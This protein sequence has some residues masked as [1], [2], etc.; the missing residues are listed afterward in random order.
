MAGCTLCLPLKQLL[1]SHQPSHPHFETSTKHSSR[2]RARPRHYGTPLQQL[3]LLRRPTFDLFSYFA[4]SLVFILAFSFMRM[5]MWMHSVF[6]FA[7]YRTAC[8][9]GHGWRSAMRMPSPKKHQ[10]ICLNK[11]Y[12]FWVNLTLPDWLYSLGKQW[13]WADYPL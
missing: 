13:Y 9:M 11:D 6:P 10:A 2:T 1:S 7:A 4:T 8:K 3:S 5:W 12:N